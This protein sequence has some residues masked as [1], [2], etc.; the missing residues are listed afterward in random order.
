MGAGR[1]SRGKSGRAEATGRRLID[2]DTVRIAND[3]HRGLTRG[4]YRS[5]AST[6]VP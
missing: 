6:Q 3:T 5:F 2:N 4:G 1:G